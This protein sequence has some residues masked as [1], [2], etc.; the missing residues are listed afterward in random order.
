MR[1]AP[2]LRERAMQF[3]EHILCNL[4]RIC[5]ASGQTKR[6]AEHTRLVGAQQLSKSVEIASSGALQLVFFTI[7]Q[8][9]DWQR[10]GNLC[11]H[12]NTYGWRGSSGCRM[13]WPSGTAGNLGIGAEPPRPARGAD[14]GEHVVRALPR[15]PNSAIRNC[16]LP[17]QSVTEGFGHLP[18]VA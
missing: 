12:T 7:C 10:L 6:D 5:T 9:S 2:D 4:V 16:S 1:G 13:R 18:R 11:G 8:R 17:P 14:F 3:Q 15:V